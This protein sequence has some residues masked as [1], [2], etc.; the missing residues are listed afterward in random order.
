MQN[1]AF[2]TLQIFAGALPWPQYRRNAMNLFNLRSVRQFR[3]SKRTRLRCET[4]D[5]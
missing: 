4:F 1:F 3:L 2:I 5:F